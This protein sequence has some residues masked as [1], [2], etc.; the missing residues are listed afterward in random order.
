MKA[1]IV[2]LIF[3]VLATA[4]FYL[5]FMVVLEFVTWGDAPWSMAEWSDQKRSAFGL[6]ATVWGVTSFF[7]ITKD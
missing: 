5:G 2:F 3:V 6:G 4:V 1:S 7:W